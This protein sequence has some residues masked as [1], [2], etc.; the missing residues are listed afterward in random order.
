MLIKFLVDQ[1]QHFIMW[2]KISNF[3]GNVIIF[4][5]D[6]RI[7]RQVKGLVMLLKDLFNDH[8]TG[9]SVQVGKRYSAL[10]S[11]RHSRY[12]YRVTITVLLFG[13]R[14]QAFYH[15]LLD[16]QVIPKCCLLIPHFLSSLLSGPPTFLH[17]NL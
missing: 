11:I 14:S 7:N 5:R 10:C 9:N 4:P 8:A 3:Y 16:N 17:L 6:L 12:D 2:E 15:T 1:G 13:V